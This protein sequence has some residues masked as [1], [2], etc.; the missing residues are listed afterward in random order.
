MI[1]APIA[2]VS[3]R[4]C[5]CGGRPDVGTSSA[6]VM[7]MAIS[8]LRLGVAHTSIFVAATFGHGAH[9]PDA[10]LIEQGRPWRTMTWLSIWRF[11][12]FLLQWSAF[13]PL[14]AW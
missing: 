9:W 12:P 3:A 2:G 13:S 6:C 7:L 5:N 14:A 11:G 10:R 8:L 4:V 1:S